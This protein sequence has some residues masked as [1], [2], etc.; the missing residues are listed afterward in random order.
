MAIV[1]VDPIAVVQ[2]RVVAALVAKGL[3]H[4]L[5]QL[6]PALGAIG[7][8][9]GPRA[10]RTTLLAGRVL[11]IRLAFLVAL[12]ILG[13][14]LVLGLLA[15]GLV[16]F[17]FGFVAVFLRLVGLALLVLLTLLIFLIGGLVL[18]LLTLRIVLLLA[19]ALVLALGL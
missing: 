2:R 15:A 4:A 17:A 8:A 13:A 3:A 9:A 16:L 7:L 19:L 5:G 12:W 14:V 1:R 10:V 11:G 6:A 18:L